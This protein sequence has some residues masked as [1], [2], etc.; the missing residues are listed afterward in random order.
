MPVDT[1]SP[2]RE[3]MM[4][5]VGIRRYST[6]K[7]PDRGRYRARFA[8]VLPTA[9]TI[10]INGVVGIVYFPQRFLTPFRPWRAG[11]VLRRFRP[12]YLFPMFRR[13]PDDQPVDL[14]GDR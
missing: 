1:K 5:T 12:P 10:T 2:V 13:A 3:H 6:H 7:P 4:V 11:A 8:R 14:L 9:F